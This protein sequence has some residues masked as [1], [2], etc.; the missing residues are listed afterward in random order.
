M[1]DCTEI[2]EFIAVAAD[3]CRRAQKQYFATRDF[4][5]LKR[6]KEAERN[7]DNLLDLRDKRI[8]GGEQLT[9]LGGN[10]V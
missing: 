9:L 10:H 3:V 4:D 2:N 8:H 1:S 5:D 6:A 7:L